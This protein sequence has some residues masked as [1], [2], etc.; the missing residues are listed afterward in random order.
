MKKLS[1]ESNNRGEKLLIMIGKMMR[2][3]ILLEYLNYSQPISKDELLQDILK[4]FDEIKKLGVNINTIS[5]RYLDSSE[6]ELPAYLEFGKLTYE[7]FLTKGKNVSDRDLRDYLLQ[8]FDRYETRG[9]VTKEALLK[10]FSP[11]ENLID[12]YILLGQRGLQAFD[13]AEH[14]N[15]PSKRIYEFWRTN[16]SIRKERSDIKQKFLIQQ[17]EPLCLLIKQAENSNKAVLNREKFNSYLDEHMPKEYRDMAIGKEMTFI[18]FFDST[19][20]PESKKHDLRDNFIDEILSES[21]QSDYVA[22]K[23]L[24]EIYNGELT[25][26]KF[27]TFYQKPEISAS[28][29]K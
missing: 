11:V 17:I 18:D 25:F 22:A 20:F 21:Q 16:A 24:L 8:A 14:L 4:T 12:A 1:E 13:A 19:D 23:N 27:E 29:Q 28:H 6:I 7:Y 15:L 10:L 26:D 3:L 9:E 2:D 5:T